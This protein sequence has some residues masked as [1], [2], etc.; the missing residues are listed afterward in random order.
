MKNIVLNVAA[1]AVCG[2]G[3]AVAGPVGAPVEPKNPIM[4]VPNCYQAGELV[5]KPFFN[6]TI[7]DDVGDHSFDDDTFYGGGLAVDYR[8]TDRF[9]VGLEGSWIDTPSVIHNYNV[10]LTYRLTDPASC[11]SLYAL[12]GGGVFTNG[13]T[14]GAAH[15]GGGVEYRLSDTFGVF[16]DGRYTWIDGGDTTATVVR[17]GVSLN[18]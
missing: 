12:G 18:L 7:F 8:Y 11:L 5:V 9:A 16:A 10:N 14:E 15:I 3:F 1:L 2:A 13:S 17:I 6:I 4:T